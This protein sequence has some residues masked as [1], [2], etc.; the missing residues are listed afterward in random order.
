MLAGVGFYRRYTLFSNRKKTNIFEPKRSGCCDIEGFA[1]LQIHV[2][3]RD[4]QSDL[5]VNVT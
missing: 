5:E 1:F 4:T 3:Y 2:G